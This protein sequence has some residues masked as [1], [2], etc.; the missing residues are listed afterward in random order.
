MKIDARGIFLILVFTLAIGFLNYELNSGEPAYT[1]YTVVEPSSVR[2]ELDKEQYLSN[3]KL[4]GEINVTFDGNLDKDTEIRIDFGDITKRVKLTDYL[5]SINKSYK[6]TPIETTITNGDDKKQFNL[7]AGTEQLVGFKIPSGATVDGAVMSV[8]GST[9]N[10]PRLL[11]LDVPEE[12][13]RPEWKYLGNFLGTYGAPVLPEGLDLQSGGSI[14]YLDSNTTYY[15]EQINLPYAK[16]FMISAK[17][18]PV[19]GSTANLEAVILSF[20]GITATGGFERCSMPR[21]GTSLAWNNCSISNIEQG[22]QGYYLVCLNIDKAER[23]YEITR[24]NSV[25]TSKYNCDM[26]F[27]ENWG[28]ATCTPVESRNYYI[29]A[30]AGLYQS[31]LTGTI[32]QQQFSNWI[33]DRPL[34]E[35]LTSYLSSCDPVDNIGNCAVIMEVKS[36]KD[37]SVEL[38]NL[39]ID[40]TE[41][42][43]GSSNT[44]TF[45][46][47]TTNSPEIYEIGNQTLNKTKLLIPL[48]YFNITTPDVTNKQQLELTVNVAG[49]TGTADIEVYSTD[50]PTIFNDV[51]DAI[52]DAGNKLTTLRTSEIAWLLDVDNEIQTLSNYQ[53]ELNAIRDANISMEEKEGRLEVIR[54]D[55]MSYIDNL[56]ATATKLS[57]ARDTVLVNPSDVE[58]LF[59]DSQEEIFS[60]QEKATVTAALTTY[61]VTKQDGS[62]DVYTIVK[63]TINPKG[64][65]KEVYVYEIIPKD[66]AQSTSDIIFQQQNFETERADPVVKY[67][68]STLI[69]TT[70]TYVIK[71]L[72]TQQKMYNIKTLIVPKKLPTQIPA[73]PEY[74]CGDGVCSRPDEDE[75]ICPQDCKEKM[76]IPWMWIG[77]I[78]GILIIGVV[79]IN[80]YKGK[81]SLGKILSRSP[82][83]TAKDLE[84]VKTYIKGQLEKKVKK[85]EISQ[86][87]LDKG[88][89]AEQVEYAFEDIKWDKKRETAMKNAPTESEDMKKLSAYIEKCKTLKIPEEK[90]TASLKAKGWK[91]AMIQQG[92]IKAGMGMKEEKEKPFFEE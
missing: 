51:D 77:I 17:Y 22:I 39:R 87:L 2:I 59:S 33:T 81:G 71:A 7:T 21:G 88:W 9:T 10:P 83:K 67:Y 90:I 36:E 13:L 47:L 28:S 23:S 27:D 16:D 4:E 70:I 56:P 3:E 14:Q 35:S 85:S 48:S 80:F 79:Y 30:Y 5:G 50:I 76:E 15:C 1:G 45:Y 92:L 20:D 78:A 41:A 84:N 72:I 42:E 61:K 38:S 65:L 73:A 37:S 29:R 32:T 52:T 86:A 66:V 6:I 82:F 75:K 74:E 68:Y 43:G 64:S 46:D 55:I 54:S 62:S 44:D 31:N 12:S 69:S 25:S 40:Y 26:G 24:D 63:K 53:V 49:K 18:R 60:Y 91:D 57:E 8:K 11:T 19:S 58:E 89:T 34:T